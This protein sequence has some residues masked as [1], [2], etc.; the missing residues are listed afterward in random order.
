MNKQIKNELLDLNSI[1]ITREDKK[2][3]N[4]ETYVPIVEKMGAIKMHDHWRLGRWLIFIGKRC[5]VKYAHNQ[6]W[7]LNIDKFL[8]NPQYWIEES[9]KQYQNFCEKRRIKK[10]NDKTYKDI[11][12]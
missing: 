7:G 11:D 8:E 4:L 9:E 1:K 6:K 10:Y 5:C 12:K 2:N 3:N